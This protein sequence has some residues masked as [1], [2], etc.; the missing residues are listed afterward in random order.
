MTLGQELAAD[1]VD[2]RAEARSRMLDTFSVETFLG[3]KTVDGTEVPDTELLFE[4]AGFI[5]RDRGF[6]VLN[7]D[8][9]GRTATTITRALHV[10]WDSPSIPAEAVVRIVDLHP[11]SDPSMHGAILR[12]AAQQGGSLTPTRRLEITERIA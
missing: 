3:W 5:E 8:V 6:G 9:G 1:V 10:P 4:T 11:T 7:Q 12:V 2:L